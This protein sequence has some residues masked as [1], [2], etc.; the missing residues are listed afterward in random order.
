MQDIGIGSVGQGVQPNFTRQKRYPNCTGI[1]IFQSKLIRRQK[2][3][4]N[5]SGQ[6]VSKLLY[7]FLSTS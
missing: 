3:I 7:D 2:F 1:I 4:K 6:H 5:I